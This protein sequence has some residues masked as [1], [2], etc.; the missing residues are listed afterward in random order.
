VPAA[1]LPLGTPTTSSGLTGDQLADA[2]VR[3]ADAFEA[4]RQHNDARPLV[5]ELL[6]LHLL[7][8][9]ARGYFRLWLDG[10]LPPFPTLSTKDE[11][12]S[13]AVRAYQRTPF[14]RKSNG[15]PRE[16]AEQKAERVLDE[17]PLRQP[18]L[19]RK[20]VTATL[21][22]RVKN[23]AGREYLRIRA[24]HDA[25]D[26]LAGFMPPERTKNRPPNLTTRR[27]PRR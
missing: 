25:I 19:W 27:R 24:Y 18:G 1:V 6:E 14:R 22:L 8:E 13:A 4:L 26:L 20:H 12:T 11:Y 3:L 21:L 2:E 23:T 17:Q 15:T 5:S 9:A 7:P 10:K 16:S